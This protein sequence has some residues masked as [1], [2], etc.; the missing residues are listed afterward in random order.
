MDDERVAQA[1]P[2]GQRLLATLRFGVGDS[3]VHLW[4]LSLFAGLGS[5]MS[6]LLLPLMAISVL[7]AT[8]SEL[9]ILNALLFAPHLVVAPF[10]GPLVDR[11][12]KRTVLSILALGACVLALVGA[13]A[14][15]AGVL[16]MQHMYLG[17][18][19]LGTF[20]SV[21]AIA[22]TP[23]VIEIVGR[24][25]LLEANSKLLMA[26]AV[27]RIGGPGLAGLLL[28]TLAGPATLLANAAFFA[29]AVVGV[30]RFP[31]AANR[32]DRQFRGLWS[33]ARD[34]WAYLLGDARLRAL[35]GAGANYNF[36]AQLTLTALL[37]FATR[38]LHLAPH[39]LGIVFAL[40]QAGWLL[41]PVL[42]GRLARALGL[43]PAI[44]ALLILDAIVV[45]P[46]PFTPFTGLAAAAWLG[47]ILF[48]HG[49]VFSAST[50]QTQTLRQI[51]TPDDLMS[52]VTAS[53]VVMTLG[54][55]PL[56]ALAGG[57]LSESIG[58]RPALFVGTLA[59]HA[60][61]LWIAL[62]PVRSIVEAAVVGESKADASV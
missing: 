36:F 34:G 25:R 15:S 42:A 23:F 27:T 52:R 9:G 35:T 12:R 46:I 30:H 33:E 60:T 11:W 24:P 45:M 55:V 47:L 38:E 22:L 7:R 14:Q 37:L 48:L 4:S 13:A 59:Y 40:G 28:T 17:A 62:S 51:L 6:A 53:Y 1:T 54:V 31:Q 50:V 3:I 20:I 58:L 49:V 21:W 29:A 26:H 56:G 19:A 8:P 18:F 16:G 41:G 32:G 10:V 2:L 43:G 39:V 57:A 61:W 44:L 5:Q